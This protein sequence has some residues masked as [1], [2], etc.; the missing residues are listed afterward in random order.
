[1]RL[2]RCDE[3]ERA[4]FHLVAVRTVE[5]N[6]AAAR[7]DVDLIAIVRCLSIGA[8]RMVHLNQQRPVRKDRHGEVAGWR[9][10]HRQGVPE[11]YVRDF[12]HVDPSL[13]QK[14]NWSMLSFLKNRGGPRMISLPRIS[15]APSL[16]AGSDWAPGAS[17]SCAISAPA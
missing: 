17:F 12:A 7:D 13:P 4:G 8:R 10:S 9:R 14:S 1:M 15:I 5:E 2:P 6:P 16:P 3:D 11:I